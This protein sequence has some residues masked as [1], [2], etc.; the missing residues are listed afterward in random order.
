MRHYLLFSGKYKGVKLKP[1]KTQ[2]DL[3]AL[4]NEI[5][6]VCFN[7]LMLV[8]PVGESSLSYWVSTSFFCAI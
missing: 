2:L 3:K 4:Y 6:N 1:K 8:S 5:L 7:R